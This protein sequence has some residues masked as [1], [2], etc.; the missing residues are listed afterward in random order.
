MK[1][2][3]KKTAR[4]YRLARLAPLAIILAG[5]LNPGTPWRD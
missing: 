3:N 5:F 1:N 4:R 2:N